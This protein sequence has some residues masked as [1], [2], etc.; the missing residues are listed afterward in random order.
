MDSELRP[1]TNQEDSS[2]SQLGAP[3]DRSASVRF[4]SSRQRTTMLL[5]IFV[6]GIGLPT[7][8]LSPLRQRLSS[9]VEI[10]RAAYG[11][12]FSVVLL[13]KIGE[14]RQQFPAEYAL[15]EPPLPKYPQIP[16]VSI[17]PAKPPSVRDSSGVRTL[18]I[19]ALPADVFSQEE[20]NP[21]ETPSTGEPVAAEP[22][23]PLY[24]RGAVEK[25]AYELLLKL[26]ASMDRL[27][28]GGDPSLKYESW[29]ALKRA[30]TIYWVRVIFS[31]VAD[32]SRMEYIWQVDIQ[33]K[34]ITP[35]SFN[36]RALAK[37]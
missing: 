28:Q 19:P 6:A 31:S 11:G 8:T 26:S 18:R 27:V 9:R 2:R 22:D 34:Q 21:V 36:A 37:S 14:N 24:Q 4:H 25:E 35:L 13:E 3:E 7:I 17:Q 10:L 12:R 23:Q 15:P 30:E 1:E 33:S 16:A 29:D 5:L 20:R 32:L